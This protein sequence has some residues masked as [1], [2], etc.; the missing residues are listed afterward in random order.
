[1]GEDAFK[2]L[3]APAQVALAGI[4][5][6]LNLHGAM[7]RRIESKIDNGFSQRIVEQQAEIQTLRTEL[8]DIDKFRRSIKRWLTIGATAII[9]PIGAAGVKLYTDGRLQSS[10]EKREMI[11]DVVKE[12]LS[13]QQWET[14]NE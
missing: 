7:L 3:P 8:Q 11:R 10:A 9:M 5:H 13:Q 12:M 14:P 4:Q 6:E 2:D 1:M